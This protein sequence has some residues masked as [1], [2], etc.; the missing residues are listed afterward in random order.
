MLPF[1]LNAML[2]TA[3]PNPTTTEFGVELPTME[4]TLGHRWK[5][6]YENYFSPAVMDDI[7]HNL[8]ATYVRTGWV[9]NWHG[10]KNPWWKENLV[11][12]SVCNS[13]LRFMI[14]VPSPRDDKRGI[15][16][17]VQDVRDFFTHFTQR[18]PGCIRYAEI[19]N[20]DDLPASG[21][22][23]VAAY[24][25]YYAQVAPIVEQFGIPIITTG[26][27]G[28]DAPFV[29]ALAATLRAS[30]PPLPVYGF[31]F[32]PYGVAVADLQSAVAQIA[33][34]AGPLWDGTRAPVYITEIGR[35]D[36]D[37][38]YQTIVTL[39]PVTPALTIYEYRAAPHEADGRYALLDHPALYDA[40]RRAF[41][42]VRAH[43]T[44]TLCP[45]RSGPST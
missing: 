1:V 15:A 24:A 10:T 20:E 33:S 34:A 36:P 32:H 13:G 31:G 17:E 29:H 28:T 8:G 23:D 12:D 4:L 39:A 6:T 40:A 42:Y 35:S 30:D 43:D 2:A 22:P 38:L 14:I 26:V 18:I 16:H 45:N 7:A 25:K 11:F 19:G 41:I 44:C 3:K 27:S 5:D 37:E 21:F 9:P